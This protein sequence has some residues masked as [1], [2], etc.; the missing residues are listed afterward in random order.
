[1]L[2]VKQSTFR[3]QL[4]I[5]KTTH[6]VLPLPEAV[7]RLAQGTLPSRAAAVTFDD[8]YRDNH[9]LALPVLQALGVPA[10]V[11]ITTGFPDRTCVLWWYV[12]EDALNAAAALRFDWKGR[13]YEF[14]LQ[15]SSQKYQAF[16]ALR[17]LFIDATLEEQARL[18]GTLMAASGFASAGHA[19]E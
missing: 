8:G 14:A 16:A 10:T 6:A 7:A 2:E 4:E 12:L 11:Y 5:L 9:A 19:G 3:R 15:N 18:A 13:R 1:C 17:P